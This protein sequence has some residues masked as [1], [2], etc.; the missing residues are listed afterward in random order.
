[1]ER[2]TGWRW[3]GAAWN[4]LESAKSGP[5]PSRCV[6]E[7]NRILSENSHNSL[8]CPIIVHC[9]RHIFHHLRIKRH[10]DDQ[11]LM[12]IDASANVI[13][14]PCALVRSYHN[15][16]NWRVKTDILSG[17]PERARS[18]KASASG[19]GVHE[20]LPSGAG[21]GWREAQR[22]G[23]G[24]APVPNDRKTAEPLPV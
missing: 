22:R 3:N 1:V 14:R 4:R 2:F 9:K 19:I 17:P 20:G 10:G 15:P 5:F 24:T 18:V 23:L 6:A 8:N 21:L 16:A 11:T 12:Q 7:G 13:S